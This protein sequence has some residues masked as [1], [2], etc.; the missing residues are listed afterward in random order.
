MFLPSFQPFLNLEEMEDDLVD[1]EDSRE[2]ASVVH[3]VLQPSAPTT[4]R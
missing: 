1:L 3:P 4:A 2:V